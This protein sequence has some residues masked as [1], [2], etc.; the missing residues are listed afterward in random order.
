MEVNNGNFGNGNFLNGSYVNEGF[1]N[2]NFPTVDFREPGYMLRQHNVG[3]TVYLVADMGEQLKADTFALKMMAHNRM[4]NIVQTQVVRRDDRRLVQFNITGF[5]KLNGWLARPRM[6]RD[7]LPVFNSL[8]NAFEEAD[9]YMLDMGH[10]L[11]DLEYVYL[12][13]QGNCMLLYLPFDSMFRK[14]QIMFLQEIVGRVQPDYQE[15]DTYL[16]DILNAFSRGGIRK[17]SDFREL[18]KKCAGIPG[19]VPEGHSLEGEPAA[20]ARENKGAAAS[21]SQEVGRGVTSVN[22]ETEKETLKK[23]PS[24]SRIPLVN[25]PGREP[26]GKTAVSI[27]VQ[28]IPENGE[29]ETGIEKSSEKKEKRKKES[30]KEGKKSFFKRDG[31]KQ[32]GSLKRN[33]FLMPGQ[34]KEERTDD[35]GEGCQVQAGTDGNAGG[36]GGDKPNGLYESYESTVMIPEPMG[37]VNGNGQ[38]GYDTGGQT[39]RLAIGQGNEPGMQEDEE[40]TMLLPEQPEYRPAACLIRRRDGEVY[41]MEKERAIIGSGSA[42]DICIYDNH[43]ISRSHAV[44]LCM[45]NEYY[46]ED[47]QSKNGSFINGRR[48]RPGVRES[49]YDG[50]VLKF[51]NEDFV[52][53]K[54][55]K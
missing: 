49:V 10:L 14:D 19:T 45:N 22:R 9:A 32:G 31:K 43:A 13:R 41:R 2:G 50:M 15:R 33:G 29:K 34:K 6:K 39:D 51:A 54:H 37:M 25:I 3:E 8:A 44:L 52:F 38:S 40:C 42:A 55:G 11:L 17:M 1:S 47:N 5:L 53:S 7:V 26:G 20:G 48:L 27:P 18:L 4:V 21:G 35:T 12:D 24:G 36:V 23:V 30:A 16:F 46:L 28:S